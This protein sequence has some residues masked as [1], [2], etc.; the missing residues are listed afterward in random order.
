MKSYD[1]SKYRNEYSAYWSSGVKHGALWYT[2][3][4]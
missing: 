2:D 1:N 3:T 4:I